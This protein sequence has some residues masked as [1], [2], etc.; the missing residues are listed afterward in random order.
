MIRIG[1]CGYGNLGRGVEEAVSIAS[2]MT[3]VGI[4]TRRSPEM[5]QSAAP[6]FSVDELDDF[7]DKIDVLILCGGSATDLIHQSPLYAKD[8]NI[9]DSFDTHDRIPEHF[10]QV[11]KA[12]LESNHTAIISSG[13]DPG[14]FSLNRLYAEAVLPQGNTYTF[15]GKGVS[16]GHSD[17]IRR[18]P[19]V[20]NGVQY[21]VP[22]EK[23]LDSVRKGENPDFTTREK[24]LRVCYVVAEPDGDK[25]AIKEA[26]VTM[27]NY[28]D[29]YDTEVHFVTEEV[30]LKEHKEM[31]HGGFVMR[32]GTLGGLTQHYEFSLAL[33]S[34][35]LFTASI[36]VAY[37]RAAHGLAEDKVYGAKTVFE[38]PPYLLSEKSIEVLRSSLL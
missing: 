5:I 32:S 2:D 38:V 24:H 1:I 16:Q 6:V 31:P 19:G 28:F 33:E 11:E 13:W 29:E 20:A 34:N 26:I 4:F 3:L 12:A 7:K 17:A 15:W 25:N 21:T 8:F 9:V 14:L 22:I 18:V 36:L 30:L 27:P 35:P 10:A 23:A 37:A